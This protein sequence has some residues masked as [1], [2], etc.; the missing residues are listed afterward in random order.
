MHASKAKLFSVFM[1]GLAASASN[2]CGGW[3]SSSATRNPSPSLPAAAPLAD[4]DGATQKTI[5]FLEDRVRRDPEDFGAHN[6][7]AAHY[8]ERLRETGN[9]EYLGLAVRAARSSLASVPAEQNTGGLAALTQAEFASHEFAAARDHALQLTK[10]EPGKGYPYQLMGDALLE[11]GD[12]EQAAVAFRS[13]ESRGG[14]SAGTET[15]LARL[16][17]L[18]GEVDVARQRFSKALALA[19]DLPAPPRE[20]VAWCRWQL[21]EVAFA[22]GDYETAERH[23]RDALVTFPDYF[24]ALASLARVRAARDDLQGAIEH[25]RRV[26]RHLPDP[27]FVAA[28][29]D[30]YHLAGREKDAAAQYAL[31]EQIG[32]LN[33]VNGALYNRQLALFYADHDIKV[34]EAYASAVKEFEVR[35]DIYGAD[36]LAWTALKAGKLNEAQAAIKEALR[37]GT[38]DAKL[39]YHAGMIA[40]AAG[41]ELA[42]R[43]YL[44]RALALNPHFDPLQASLAREALGG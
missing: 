17:L 1:L 7:L 14:S 24:N 42:A 13:M 29:G 20:V 6:R 37:L 16:A 8:F 43:D 12:Y 27:S 2:A 36:A 4:S 25:Y 18:R 39:F 34:E 19:L 15:R 44:R 31:V 11:L 23:Y 35:R 41:D 26:V 21:G 30:L 32:R 28:L 5:R 9:T 38:R 33:A 22:V 3:W 10:L 40:R